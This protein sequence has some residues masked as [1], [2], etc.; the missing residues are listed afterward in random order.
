MPQPEHRR[1]RPLPW[2]TGGLPMDA[3]HERDHVMATSSGKKSNAL[4]P[5]TLLEERQRHLLHRVKG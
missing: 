4:D 5:A 2:R 3:D 1:Y